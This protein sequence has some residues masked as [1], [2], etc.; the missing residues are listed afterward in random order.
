MSAS[1]QDTRLLHE[2]EKLSFYLAI[3][4]PT[5]LVSIDS[6]DDAKINWRLH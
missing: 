1:K 6:R 2:H 5:G 3:Q 4:S